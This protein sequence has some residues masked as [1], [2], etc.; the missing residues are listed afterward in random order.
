MVTAIALVLNDTNSVIK[1]VPGLIM[2]A[3]TNIETENTN[4]NIPVQ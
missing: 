4:T 1:S 3:A 2:T